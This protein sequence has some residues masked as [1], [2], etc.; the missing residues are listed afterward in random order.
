MLAA[1]RHLRAE[2]VDQLIRPLRGNLA[3]LSLTTV[4]KGESDSLTQL[5]QGPL[6]RI[7]NENEIRTHD[8][9]T[10]MVLVIQL[11]HRGI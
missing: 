4:D 1:T 7:V 3:G 2:T 8:R 10:L 11:D 5:L 6:Q 9:P